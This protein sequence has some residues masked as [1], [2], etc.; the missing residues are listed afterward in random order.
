MPGLSMWSLASQMSSTRFYLLLLLVSCRQLSLGIVLGHT[1]REVLWNALVPAGRKGCGVWSAVLWG[2]KHSDFSSVLGRQTV[3][4]MSVGREER[5]SA[6]AC[7]WSMR[8]HTQMAS[9]YF[10]STSDFVLGSSKGDQL[11]RAWCS[12]Q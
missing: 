3:L 11:V 12:S 4:Q 10:N 7:V 1:T 2:C 5:V 9:C 8:K 6:G